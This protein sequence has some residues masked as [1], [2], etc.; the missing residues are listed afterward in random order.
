MGKSVVDR[1]KDA[2]KAV[3]KF[4]DSQSN[5]FATF[6]FSRLPDAKSAG[7]RFKAMPADFDIACGHIKLSA[8]VEVKCSEHD[9]RIAKDKIAQLARLRMWALAG[10]EFAVVVHHS[11]IDKWR[12]A[13][14]AFFGIDWTPPSWDLSSLPLYDTAEE[15]LR[16]T[17]WFR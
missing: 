7:G 3:Q 14:K 8:F 15:A 16:S 9:Y 5:R 2:E 11:S 12:V 13:T 10:R 4:F 17:G 1:G 6:S